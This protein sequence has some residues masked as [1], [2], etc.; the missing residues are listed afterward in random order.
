MHN[1]KSTKH[2]ACQANIKISF[3]IKCPSVHSLFGETVCSVNKL[4]WLRW[5]SGWSES[6]L[7]AE[8]ICLVSYL[9]KKIS[10][11]NVEYVQTTRLLGHSTN[12]HFG[13]IH[14]IDVNLQFET[15]GLLILVQRYILVYYQSVCIFYRYN[16]DELFTFSKTTGV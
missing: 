2:H 16:Q 13:E 5:C 1:I 12:S 3:G 10:D 9:Y 11:Q 6:S 14:A 7:T 15:L 4:I 8:V